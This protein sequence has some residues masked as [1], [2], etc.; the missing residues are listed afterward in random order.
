MS[1]LLMVHFSIALI[2]ITFFNASP[3]GNIG[4]DPGIPVQI[5]QM[6][7]LG[8]ASWLSTEQLQKSFALERSMFR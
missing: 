7:V 3:L 6:F 8:I 5:G 1:V 4:F 2:A